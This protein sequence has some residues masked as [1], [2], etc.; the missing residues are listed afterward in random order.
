MIVIGHADPL[1]G[2]LGIASSIVLSQGVSFFFVLSGFILAWNYPSLVSRSER[3]HF[4]L[5]RFA[6]IWPLHI[7]T[8]GLWI[9]LVYSFDD[10]RRFPDTGV[11][12]LILNIFLLQSWV[13]LK[14]WSLSFNGV[15]WSISV[16]MFF[17]LMFP[18]LIV[19]VRR[20]WHILLTVLFVSLALYLIGLRYIEDL[21]H[22]D[23]LNVSVFGLIYTNPLVRILEFS[24][25]ISLSFL[26]RKLIDSDVKLTRAQWFALE[27]FAI[28]SV[29]ISLVAAV[30][31]AGIRR[32][33]GTPVEYYVSKAG[34]WFPWAILIGIFGLSQGHIAKLLS[35]KGFVFL[36]EISFALYLCH[37]LILATIADYTEILQGRRALF[38]TLYW[39]ACLFFAMLLFMGIEKPFRRCIL[40]VK[41]GGSLKSRVI[42]N[43]S[44]GPA[45]ALAGLFFTA[46]SMYFFRPSTIFTLKQAQISDFLSK[47]S[48]QITAP[49]NA[50]FDGRYR[51]EAFQCSSIGNGQARIRMLM[52]S[53]VS[54]YANDALGLHVLNEEGKITFNSG[55]VMD[56]GRFEVAANQFWVE[57]FDVPAA[58]LAS[59]SDI[60]VAMFHTVS[61]LFPYSGADGDWNGRR[62]KLKLQ[63]IP[64][65]QDCSRATK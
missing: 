16:E 49:A 27:I 26:I 22:E 11:G 30:D 31:L 34:L 43:F 41:G 20:H 37:A 33:F 57:S 4:W 56:F 55:R 39:I 23:S 65:E 28:C 8:L 1:F 10:G 40:S 45:L 58:T 19:L 53:L 13:P 24:V 47:Q 44:G 62:M 60:G 64:G 54:T 6:R 50:V 63:K 59:A 3:N 46:L 7:T 32:I 42:P 2:S 5:A 36:G 48:N 35:K 29:I 61:A 18:L 52:H 25:G 51:I 14:A 21:N 15:S 17:Y 12:K 9:L 38:Y